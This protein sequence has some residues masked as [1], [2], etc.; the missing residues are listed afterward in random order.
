MEVKIVVWDKKALIQLNDTFDF[1]KTKSIISA[2]KVIIILLKLTDELSRDFE[3]YELDRFKLKNDGSFRAF[4]QYN[5]R[6]SYRVT[7]NQIRIL[8]VRHTSRNP[9]IY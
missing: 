9:K 5:Y 1:L 2:K 6:I 7:S 4:E 3:I 8:R